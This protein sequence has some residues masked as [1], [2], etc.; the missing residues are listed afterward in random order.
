MDDLIRSEEVKVLIAKFAQLEHRVESQCG[1]R[2]TSTHSEGNTSAPGSSCLATEHQHQLQTLQEEHGQIQRK[3]AHVEEYIAQLSRDIEPL[4]SISR[5][6]ERRIDKL[7]SKKMMTRLESLESIVDD[8]A[9]EHDDQISALQSMCTES[10]EIM[11]RAL[12]ACEENQNRIHAMA[13]KWNLEQN[14]ISADVSPN[15]SRVFVLLHD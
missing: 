6:C 9:R 11:Q 8:T 3:F 15:L 5:K 10:R 4:A 13:T 2:S 12:D 7:A 14:S 1:Y